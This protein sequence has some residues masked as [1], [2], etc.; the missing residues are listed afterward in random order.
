ME[1]MTF[2][3]VALSFKRRSQREM[4]HRCFWEDSTL[5][6]RPP[7]GSSSIELK[8]TPIDRTDILSFLREKPG[9]RR[10]DHF[11]ESIDEG[12]FLKDSFVETSERKLLLPPLNELEGL[13]RPVYP[14]C[15]YLCRDVSSEGSCFETILHSVRQ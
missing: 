6:L 11:I 8:G 9:D 12:Q 5:G 1:K 4:L 15:R 3:R 10:T 7:G 14:T 2:E 13:L